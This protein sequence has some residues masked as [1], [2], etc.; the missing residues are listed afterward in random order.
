M[1]FTEDYY[2]EKVEILEGWLD[3]TESLYRCSNEELIQFVQE[4]YTCPILSK[5]LTYQ[6]RMHLFECRIYLTLDY[7]KKTPKRK[8]QV[9]EQFWQDLKIITAYNAMLW[10][11]Y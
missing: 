2:Q 5:Y 4:T 9:I 6:E 11:Y 8:Q 1:N 3:K 7:L 10:N